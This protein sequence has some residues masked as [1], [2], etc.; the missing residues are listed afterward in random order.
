VTAAD[1]FDM[2]LFTLD[3]RKILLVNAGDRGTE[4]VVPPAGP[5]YAFTRHKWAR[6]VEVSVSPT[7]RSVR[8]W[9]DGKEVKP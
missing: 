2:T 3:G 7:G 6:K 9:V 5:A 1:E 4:E 8:V